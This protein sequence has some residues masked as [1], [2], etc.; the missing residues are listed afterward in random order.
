M[1]APNVPLSKIVFNK[2]DTDH[3][4]SITIQEFKFMAYDLGYYLSD[5]ELDLA[6]KKLDKSGSDAITYEDFNKWWKTADRWKDLQLSEENMAI[7]SAISGQ[8]QM[9]DLDKSGSINKEEFQNYSKEV[10]KKG[11]ITIAE[12]EKMFNDLDVNHDGQVTFN[13]LVDYLNAKY[14]GD[15]SKYFS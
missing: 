13:E 5:T 7:L 11:N 9:F 8:F 6:V 3:S 14:Q 10:A 15:L 4:G 1:F 2:Y 12:Q